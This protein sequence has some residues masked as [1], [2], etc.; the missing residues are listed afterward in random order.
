M[1]GT[2]GADRTGGRQGKG[3]GITGFTASAIAVADMVGIGVFTS[4]GFQVQDIQSAF[5]VLLLWVVGGVVAL[6]GAL[7]YGE[8]AAALPRSGVE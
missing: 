4:L 6:C 5:S 2:R 7:S 1:P 8:L 3:G